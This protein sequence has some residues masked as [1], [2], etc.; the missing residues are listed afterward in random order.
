MEVEVESTRKD[1]VAMG[2]E[3]D[4]EVQEKMILRLPLL[5]VLALRMLCMVL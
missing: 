3:A 4:T 5:A 1:M 2:E